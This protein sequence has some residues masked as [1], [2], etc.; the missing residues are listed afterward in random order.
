MNIKVRISNETIKEKFLKTNLT[1]DRT[2]IIFQL[3]GRSCCRKHLID[4]D[5][6]EDFLKNTTPT[7]TEVLDSISDAI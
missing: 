7:H 4:D 2:L 5:D 1:E 6:L 3:D